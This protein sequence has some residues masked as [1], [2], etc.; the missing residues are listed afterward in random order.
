LEYLSRAKRQW[1]EADGPVPKFIANYIQSK[2]QY[3]LEEA[4]DGELMSVEAILFQ[5]RFH[6]IG[7]TSRILYSKNP[8]VEMGSC[9]PFPH[10]LSAR[11]VDLVK[12]AHLDI[13]FTDGP[14]HTEV[15]VDARGEIEIIDLNPRFI[16][17]DVLQSINFA[18]G[19]RIEAALLDWS[20]GI[21]PTIAPTQ[22][23][24]S[25][26]QYLLPPCSLLFES[27]QFPNVP[28]IKFH[29]TFVQPGTLVSDINRQIDYLGCY[30]TVL[31][32]FQGAIDRSREL[33][34][35]VLINGKL[36]GAY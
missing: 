11:I 20:L 1:Q 7:L 6:Q 8:I 2:P 32:S 3:H 18:F 14:S 16:G 33:R 29:T 26:I 15:I 35:A 22:T 28:E 19:I 9:F 36:E 4:F 31:P 5:G 17:A 30:L 27:I 13:G 10:P 21:E 23:G 34:K 25:C 12:R 24:F